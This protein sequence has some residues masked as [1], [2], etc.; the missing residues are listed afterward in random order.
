MTRRDR[1]TRLRRSGA[2]FAAALALVGCGGGGEGGGDEQRRS[3][4]SVL[5]AEASRATLAKGTARQYLDFHTEPARRLAFTMD[6]VVDMR[7]DDSR[8]TIRYEAFE[9]VDPGTEIEIIT[10]DDIDYFRQ[11]G[12]E[13]WLKTETTEE[14]AVANSQDVPD[15]LRNLGAV[16]NDAR[17]RGRESIRGVP[18]TKYTATVDAERIPE[19]LPPDQRDTARRGL[20]LF[21]EPV[22]PAQVWIDDDGL[23][24][25]LRYD[26]D[27]DNLR[28]P[29]NGEER[30]VMTVDLFGFGTDARVQAPPP[31][32][33]V[34]E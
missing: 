15:G 8:G 13:T 16:T 23:I 3:E 25:R 27:F 9:G 18:T 14:D 5:I 20:R 24:R 2:V 33:T 4:A 1:P 32:Q 30:M 17:A 19:T 11:G 29:S 6:G 7:A 34:D 21:K 28:A 22:L 31:E 26:F 10:F 12:E